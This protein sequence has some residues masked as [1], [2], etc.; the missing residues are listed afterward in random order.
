MSILKNIFL[1]LDKS[2]IFPLVIVILLTIPTTFSLFKNDFFSSFD[3]DTHVVRFAK[4]EQSLL[5]G[6]I[7]PRWADGLAFNLGSPVLMY[8]EQLTFYLGEVIRLF[9]VSLTST[10]EI[11]LGLSL[12]L[13]GVTFYFF[14]RNIF[15][16]WAAIVGALFYVWAPYRFVDI[17]VR[18]ELAES[19]SLIFLPLILLS[20]K[21]IIEK[22][23][24]FWFLVNIL[25]FSGLILSHILIA[26]MVLLIYPIYGLML[27]KIKGDLNAFFRAAIAFGFSFLI[28][29]YFWV[30][31]YFERGFINIDFLNKTTPFKSNFVSIS[32]IFYSKWGWGPLD[33]TSPMSLQLGLTQWIVVI[34]SFFIMIWFLIKKI[35][36]NKL[37]ISKIQ[38]NHFFLFFVIFLVSI[39]LMTSFSAFFWENISYLSIFLYPW[40][41]LILA[42][43][44]VSILASFLTYFI[45]NNKLI[46]LSLILLLLYFNRN[47]MQLVG[48]VKDND[49]F[50]QN[51]LDTTDMWGEYLPTTAN[52]ELVKSCKFKNCW[53]NKIEVPPGVQITDIISSNDNLS[54]KYNNPVD[55][56]STINTFY[57]PGW[58]IYLDNQKL[59]NVTI[60]KLGTMDIGLKAGKHVVEARFEETLL[61]KFSLYLSLVSLMVLF[62]LMLKKKLLGR[63]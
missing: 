24:K 39:F 56:K 18:G 55:F 28:T 31:A 17:Y 52:L 26:Y 58:E 45:K 40:R 44:S 48:V 14:A 19:F 20:L 7:I 12:V 36:Q 22:A 30:P 62:L 4:F 57:F 37:K 43:F 13:S 54:F 46:I 33:S 49:R 16:S 2:S 61:K 21:K 59:S 9:Q 27:I 23:D 47:H 50:F 10:I 8:G 32:Q 38:L 1:R 34:I 63:S 60:N 5:S 29:A 35:S 41:F 6:Q 53:F 11:L 42:T 51:Y 3:G 25:S 15:G